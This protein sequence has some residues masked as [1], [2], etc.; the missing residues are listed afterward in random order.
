MFDRNMVSSRRVEK[1]YAK[2]TKK[3]DLWLKKEGGGAY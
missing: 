1:N 3:L 2:M